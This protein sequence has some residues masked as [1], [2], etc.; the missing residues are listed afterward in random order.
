MSKHNVKRFVVGVGIPRTPLWRINQ[1]V[2]QLPTSVEYDF[3]T[4][5]LNRINPRTQSLFR[6]IN[7]NNSTR[8]DGGVVDDSLVWVQI[9]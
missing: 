3:L 2:I 6:G 8:I 1:I 9:T 7:D 4:R 5:I